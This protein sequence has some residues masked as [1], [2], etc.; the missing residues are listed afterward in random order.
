MVCYLRIRKLHF[1]STCGHRDKGTAA[2]VTANSVKNISLHQIKRRRRRISKED[3]DEDDKT[4]LLIIIRK[5]G[6]SA[7]E[8]DTLIH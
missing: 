4:E 8:T 6:G 7:M 1:S 5:R 3:I 2:G